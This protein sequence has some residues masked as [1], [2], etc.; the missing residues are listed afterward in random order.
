MS[1]PN[2]GLITE[3][4]RQ[5]YAGA[6]QFYISTTGKDQTFTSTFDTDLVFGNSDPLTGDYNKNSFKIFTSPNARVWTELTPQ[7]PSESGIVENATGV[8]S[9]SVDLTAFNQGITVGMLVAGVGIDVGTKV[10]SVSTATPIT[11]TIEVPVI[12]VAVNLPTQTGIVFNYTTFNAAITVNN[13]ILKG[14]N[15][16]VITNSTTTL[17]WLVGANVVNGLL[18]TLTRSTTG[19]TPTQPGILFTAGQVLTAN[20]VPTVTQSIT[21]TLNTNILAGMGVSGSTTNAFG[22]G[23][24]VLAAGI[25]VRSNTTVAGKSVIVLET[26]AGLPGTGTIYSF[27]TSPWNGD[28]LSFSS[29][30]I[31]L[32]KN[33]TV[34]NGET[35]TFGNTNPFTALNNIVTVNIFLNAGTYLKIQLNEDTMQ[36]SNGSYEYTRLM[37]V[38]DNFLIAYVGAG[39]IIPSVKR[40]DV[41]F[42]A[43]RG[44]QEFSYDTLKSV[45]SS[46]LTVPSSLSLTI[47][48]DYVNYVRLSWVDNL[49]VL[50]IIYP[51]NNLN[52]SPYYT[53]GQDDLGNPI[54]DSNDSNTEVTSQINATWNKTDPRQI[55]GAFTN[56]LDNANTVFD[57]SVYSGQL[58][59]R[60]GMDPQTSQ[61]NGWFKIDER[62]GT[63]SFTSNLANKL[64]L[65]QYISDGNAYDLDARIP[66][67]AED[68]LYSHIAHAILATSA[69]TQEYIVQRFKRER[70]AKLRNAKIRLSNL[71]LDQIIQVMRG[72]SKWIK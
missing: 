1:I 63:F 53:F 61:K 11:G 15:I 21:L 13:F 20:P 12:S 9:K 54:Q 27:G 52:Q 42:H 16:P 32:D 22:T 31:T 59:Q 2:G 39:K 37:D 14:G 62:K 64:I 60:Y 41:V 51:T 66:K 28:T 30:E 68:A 24:V 46:E 5:Y 48:Q 8:A 45:K 57:Q 4:N 29:Q 38:I 44:L 26:G 36:D 55:S 70:S 19:N 35:L 6:Q 50:H 23:K 7:N 56:N 71:K 72:K 10:A 33:A 34:V 25:T 3:T 65:L 47:P 67:L 58:G 18:G 40:S 43:K 69:N 17:R 49:G